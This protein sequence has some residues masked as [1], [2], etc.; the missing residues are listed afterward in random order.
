MHPL[1][2]KRGHIGTGR[3][4]NHLLKNCEIIIG[5]NFDHNQTLTKLL[6][7]N[8]YYPM[9][10]YPGKKSYN[11]SKKEFPKI[12]D[13]KTPLILVID[14]TWPCAKSMMRDSKI[15]HGLPRVSFESSIES[16][17]AIKHQPDKFC[18]STLESIQVVL[19]SLEDMGLESLEENIK[20][21]PSV[22]ASIVKF[23]MECA[24]DPA[25]KNHFHDV[26]KTR[27]YKPPSERE[28]SKRWDHRK[29]CFE[30]DNY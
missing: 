20:S 5:E 17:F 7:D 14:G 29:I 30:E 18:L 25:R 24:K 1:E 26:D 27:T 21:L 8:S 4:T 15:L 22:L 2:A 10:L 19:E 13:A 11:L 28:R 9:L 23:Q 3:P 6:S 16:K 12:D